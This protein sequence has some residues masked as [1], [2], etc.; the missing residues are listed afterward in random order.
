MA[1]VRQRGAGCLMGH[2]V[3]DALGGRYEF[4]AGPAAA[5]QVEQD[6]DAGVLPLLGGGPHALF[7][8]A[9][10]DDTEMLVTLGTALLE[11]PLP[12][13]S[14]WL[15]RV[16]QAYRAWMLS[17]PPDIGMTV[18]RAIGGAIAVA[19]SSAGNG[20]VHAAAATN[21]RSASNGALMRVPPLVLVGLAAQAPPS[22]E[23]VL[24]RVDQECQLTHPS[25]RARVASRMYAACLYTLVTTGSRKDAHAAALHRGGVRGDALLEE[26]RSMAVDGPSAGFVGIALSLSLQELL[27]TPPDFAGSM[28]RLLR[29]GGD[30]DTNAAIAG[31]L[32]G[33]ALTPLPL[34]WVTAVRTAPLRPAFLHAVCTGEPGRWAASASGCYTP[35]AFASALVHADGRRKKKSGTSS[36][37]PRVEAGQHGLPPDPQ[38][39]GC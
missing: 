12:P 25:A 3:G 8:G 14:T 29:Q 33:A 35:V 26:A 19:G 11:S 28:T 21:Q 10:T 15:D 17:G 6:E 23:E 2:A 30:T 7:P 31:A 27:R 24:H 1:D 37:S 5:A 16:A 4:L 36:A 32:L 38:G 20:M 13:P 34:T 18:R 9:G 22:L 39:G